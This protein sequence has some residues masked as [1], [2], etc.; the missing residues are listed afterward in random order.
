[1]LDAALGGYGA[2]RQLKGFTRPIRRIAQ[3]LRDQGLVPE[4][5]IDVLETEYDQEKF[6]RASGF[7]LAEELV[8][9]IDD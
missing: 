7:V 9:L 1:M 6:G 4:E 2:E 5:A 8:P 3:D